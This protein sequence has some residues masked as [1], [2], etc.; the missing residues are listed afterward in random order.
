MK[1]PS[2]PT[3]P[4]LQQENTVGVSVL[5]GLLFFCERYIYILVD[6]PLPLLTSRHGFLHFSLKDYSISIL[7][8]SWE[9][10]NH[11]LPN[12]ATSCSRYCLLARVTDLQFSRPSFCKFLHGLVGAIRLETDDIDL[13]FSPLK[14]R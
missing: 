6:Y 3:L 9:K 2:L 12:N 5:I 4:A 1:D 13:P 10:T 7:L 8:A 14:N 11:H